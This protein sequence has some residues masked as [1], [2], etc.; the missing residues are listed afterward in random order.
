MKLVDKP[1]WK[2]NPLFVLV[3]ESRAGKTALSVG[4]LKIWADRH[5]PLS[6]LR[7]VTSRPPRPNDPTE[8]V[9]YE[10]TSRRK[11]LSLRRRGQLLEFVEYA[12]NVYGVTQ[13]EAE[14]ALGQGP[15]V[16]A[17]TEEGYK[18]FVRAG[19]HAVP[20]KILP[21]NRPASLDMRDATRVAEDRRRGSEDIGYWSCVD[22]D[23]SPGGHAQALAELQR[24]A[25]SYLSQ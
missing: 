3:G 25:M 18:D 16:I 23:F 15:A 22:N 21:K 5:R 24:S 6:Y 20:V 8:Q 12:G 9:V 14:R 2:T 7:T 11:I 17:A 1:A 19:L 10:F 13:A 4:L